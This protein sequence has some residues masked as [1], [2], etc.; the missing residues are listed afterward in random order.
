MEHKKLTKSEI[1]IINYYVIHRDRTKAFKLGYPQSVNWKAET[2]ARKADEFF[3]SDRIQYFRG[4]Q[5]RGIVVVQEEDLMS[6]ATLLVEMGK[7]PA[8]GA[9]NGGGHPSRYRP[10][11]PKI[12]I[13]FFDIGPFKVEEYC[14]ENTGE[15]TKSVVTNALPT[16]A[17]FAAKLRVS[18]ITLDMWATK[19]DDAGELRYPEFAEAYKIVDAMIE[20]ILVTNTL[21]GKY[22]PS[23]A[24]FFAKNKLGYK[25]KSDLILEGGAKPIVSI[26][27]NMT[28]EEAAIIYKESLGQDD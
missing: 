28:A 15:V 17:A 1:K 4:F 12:M 16:K 21:M 25:D 13:D 3:D 5:D 11:F 6:E 10:E 9:H 24:Q 2:I 7:V 22:Q 27:A 23:F 18:L 26:G 8:V 19:L 14:N 20:N